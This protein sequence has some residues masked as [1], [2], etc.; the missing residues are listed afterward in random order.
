MKIPRQ[1]TLLGA[2]A[3]LLLG[4][5]VSGAEGNIHDLRGLQIENAKIPVLNKGRLQMV[6]FSSNAE[7][8]GEMLTGKHTVLALIRKGADPDKIRDDWNRKSY[9]LGAPLKEVLEFWKDRVVYS[10]GFMNTPE[11]EIDTTSRHRAGGNRDVHFRSPLLDLDGVGFEADFARRTITINSDVHI[12][13]RL[14]SADP[15][16]LLKTPGKLPAKYEYITATG[17][18]LL[19]D[20]K[21]DE[22]MLIG[23]VRVDEEQAYLTCDRLTLFRGEGAKEKDITTKN[24][25]DAMDIEGSG[26]DRIL[27]DGNVVITKRSNPRERILADHLIYDVPKG[28]ARFSGDKHHPKMISANGDVL[29]GRDLYFQPATRRGRVIGECRIDIAPKTDAKG[30]KDAAKVLTADNAY[31]DTEGDFADL[32]G[33][34]R[35]RDGEVSV[36]CDRARISFAGAEKAASKSGDA[37]T[38]PTGSL[39]GSPD[40]GTGGKSLKGADLYGHVLL[41]QG[42]NSQLACERMHVDFSPDKK[43]GSELSAARCFRKVRFET[44][45]GNGTPPGVI[46]SDRADLGDG[47]N[48]ATFEGNVRGKREKATLD[49]DKLDLYFAG[50]KSAGKSAPEAKTASIG[51]DGGRS[52]R[53]VVATGRTRVTD[54]SGKLDCDKLTLFFSALPPGAKAAPGMFQAGDSRLTDI[55]ADGHVVAVNRVSASSKKQSGLVYGK[56][57]GD[58]TLYADHGQADLIRHLSHFTGNVRVRDDEHP[59]DCDDMYIYGVRRAAAAA[60]AAC[61]TISVQ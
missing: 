61:M 27:A 10:T 43:G 9:P 20:S 35:M 50:K 6:I 12:V 13:L 23:H 4:V 22:F 24:V 36:N 38:P 18:S 19:I 2:A 15:E 8:R 33:N 14:R 26:I 51:M 53:K 31:L 28:T 11:A 40:I 49:C 34:V 41:R 17:D 32:S 3:A 48:R 30:A 59:L 58:R 46:T 42:T 5:A 45:G 16:K 47:G 44:T 1:T 57:S 7:L 56:S 60:A 39:L 52:I 29:S 21:R 37:K 54:E 55:L 25:P